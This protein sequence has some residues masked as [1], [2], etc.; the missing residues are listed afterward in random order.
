[1]SLSVAVADS[2]FCDWQVDFGPPSLNYSHTLHANFRVGKS[3]IIINSFVLKSWFLAMQMYFF[4]FQYVF[5]FE[6]FNN[7]YDNL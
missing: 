3:E 5:K 1:M 7:I 2:A 4:Y 6:K